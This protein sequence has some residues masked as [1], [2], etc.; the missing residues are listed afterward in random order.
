MAVESKGKKPG[1]YLPDGEYDVWAIK[2]CLNPDFAKEKDLCDFIEHNIEEFCASCLGVEYGQHFR[3]YGLK[4]ARRTK[5]SKRIDFLIVSKS[6]ERIGVECKN[7]TYESEL[8]GAIGQCLSYMTIFGISGKPI[9]R[10]AIVTTKMDWSTPFTIDKF[11]LPI[12]LIGMDKSK[13]IGFKN[14]TAKGDYRI[15]Q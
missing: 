12:S 7:P 6:G 8:Q 2:S 4:Q 5:G 11:N 3:E 13:F 15:S 14:G 10:I 1:F 9:D